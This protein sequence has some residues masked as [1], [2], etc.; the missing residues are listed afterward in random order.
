MGKYSVPPQI[1]A[2]KPDGTMVKTKN[3]H[4]YVYEYKCHRIRNGVDNN[5][6][7]K[8]KTVTD[9]GPCIG[10]IIEDEGFIS[11]S[12]KRWMDEITVLEYGGYA[13]SRIISKDTFERLKEFFIRKDA[14]QIYVCGLIIFNE[15]FT[16]MTDMS[17]KY[18]ESIL[19][20]FFP[21]TKVGYDALYELY[22]YLGRRSGRCVNLQQRLI[23]ESSKEIAIVGH[24]IACTS[25]KNDLSEYGYKASK[26]GTPQINYMSAYDVLDDMPL[27]SSIYNG[28]IP[29][30]SALQ[31][32]FGK[33]SFSNCSFYVDR[34]FNTKADKDLMSIDGNTYI[35]PMIR[36]RDDYKKVYGAIKF[37]KRRWFVYGKDGYSSTIYYQEFKGEGNIRYIAFL[38]VTRQ[39][40]E[41]RTYMEKLN[42]GVKGYSQEGLENSEKD[43]GL[44]LLETND[45]SLTAEQ[46]FARYKKRWRIET[47]YNYIDN[48]IDFNALY[49]R[50][51]CRTEGVG[52][53]VHVAGMIFHDL[54][55]ELK[56]YNYSV[57]DVMDGF[58]GIKAVKEQSNWV[59]RNNNKTRQTLANKIGFDIP[60]YI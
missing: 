50:D 41:R 39:D 18:D 58:R 40:A 11:N 19:S 47:F 33:F 45:I 35:V 15:G 48:T 13:Y 28:S 46:V 34:G 4:Y 51:Y 43:F 27:A 10:Q 5:G 36:G 42:L 25:Q 12:A 22:S 21:D 54:R 20:K 1:L 56:K 32:L 60:D 30:K 29:D 24:V 37:D 31:Q 55:K 53:V 3:N 8:W 14:K 7:T 59:I 38:D 17:Q 23:N 26:I 49:Q 16:Y 52:F 2:L 57:R 44:F 9:M 6:K